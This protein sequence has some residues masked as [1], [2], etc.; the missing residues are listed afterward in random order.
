VPAFLIVIGFSDVPPTLTL[1]R[2]RESRGV[3]DILG[4]CE[5]A[6]DAKTENR[7]TNKLENR[8]NDFNFIGFTPVVYVPTWQ[9]LGISL[10]LKRPYQAISIPRERAFSKNL[11]L[12]RIPVILIS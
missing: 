4:T 8:T 5:W 12:K 2:L 10:V 7:R 6:G 9:G 11:S 3:T 1:P